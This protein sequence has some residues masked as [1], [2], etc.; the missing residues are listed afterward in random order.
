MIACH[1]IGSGGI[2]PPEDPERIAT[3]PP[4]EG[5]WLWYDVQ[6]PTVQEL[7]ALQERLH[8]HPLA[9]E[10]VR[11]RGQRPKVDL[12]DHHC[13]V[14][15]RPLGVSPGG[16]VVDMEVQV[17]ASTDWLVTVRFTPAF[18]LRSTLDRWRARS[19][20]PGPA[21]ALY[22][23]IDEVADGYLGIVEHLEDHADDLEDQ[24]FGRGAVGDD[25]RTLQARILRLRRE[26]VRMRRF[27]MP[28]RQALDLLMDDGRFV[29]EHLVPYYRDVSEHLLRSVELSDNVRDILTTILEIRTAQAANQLNE[30]MKKLTAW[31]GIILVPTLI[32]GIYGMNFRDMPE[33]RWHIGYPVAI[34]MMAA[35]AAV[36]YWIFKKRGWL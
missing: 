5:A 18:D 24:V 34:G 19:P 14:V 35:S 36:L 29:P 17:F 13:F 25:E 32:A 26:V 16:D 27:A 31:A 21:G 33:L 22:A 6:D 30:V 28:L 20:E 8:L 11:H 1:W 15:M 9:I 7:T 23:L 2:G 3:A 10:D 12:F 4:E